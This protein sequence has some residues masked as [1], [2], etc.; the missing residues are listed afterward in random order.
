M[1]QV[2]LR[3]PKSSNRNNDQNKDANYQHRLK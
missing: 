2:L 3:Q 1:D